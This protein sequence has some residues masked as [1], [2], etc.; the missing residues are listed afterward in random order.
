[1]S[2][3]RL[4]VLLVPAA[5]TLCGCT[6]SVEGTAT[7]APVSGTPETASE[8]GDLILAEVP[9]RLPRLPDDDLDPPAGAKT[10]EDVAAYADDPERERGVLEDYGYRHG[11]ERFWGEGDGP[12][13]IVFVDQFEHRAG[14]GA[15]AEDL[16]RN[17][18]EHY[19]AMLQENP[20]GLPGNCWSL[21]VP[22]PEPDLGLDGPAAFAWC[23]HGVFSV[24]VTAIAESVDAA[25]EEM[26]AVVEL[27]L[28]LL[29]P[30]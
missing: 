7:A 24:R 5:L 19:R 14:A 12:T 1:V 15:Y 16:A 2:A 11:W 9:S 6:A 28:A 13:T 22:D 3:G 10:V 20:A 18:A 21:T 29:P 17:E 30:G 25:R 27:Q 4:V 8:L 26:R 23:G